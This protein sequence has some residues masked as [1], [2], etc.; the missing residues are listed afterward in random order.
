MTIVAVLSMCSLGGHNVTTVAC[1]CSSL[2]IIVVF[3]VV[4]VLYPV[5]E[6]DFTHLL[7]GLLVRG[8]RRLEAL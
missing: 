5:R 8:R 6:R 4:L 2:L 1:L 3:G 7:R